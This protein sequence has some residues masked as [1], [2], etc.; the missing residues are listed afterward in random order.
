MPL[1]L[2]SFSSRPTAKGSAAMRA[3]KTSPTTSTGAPSRRARNWRK[4][5]RAQGPGLRSAAALRVSD[6]LGD[7]GSCHRF[8]G[9][10][11][12]ALQLVRH[13]NR[14]PVLEVQVA[15]E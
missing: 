9:D 10:G 14:V 1:Q 8:A 12:E 4:K 5:T 15:V 7:H 2:A 6:Q 11:A 13:R 3:T